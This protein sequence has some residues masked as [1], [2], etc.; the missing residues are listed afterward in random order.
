MSIFYAGLFRYK[1][2]GLLVFRILIGIIF[3][4]HGYLTFLGGAPA[5][6]EA[7]TMI[8]PLG[9]SNGLFAGTLV[10]TC[11]VVGGFLL[12]LGLLTRFAAFLLFL[13]FF[14]LFI[15]VWPKGFGYATNALQDVACFLLFLIAGP[16]RY[17]LDNA[18]FGG[19]R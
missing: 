10:A 18:I 19:R 5:L 1:D 15:Q 12:I 4:Y 2:E 8:N 13:I 17:S 7:G 16:G 9:I 14:L 3:L 6:T 11:E